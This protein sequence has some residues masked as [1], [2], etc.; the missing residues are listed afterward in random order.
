ME[1][2]DLLAVLVFDRR[3]LRG[4]SSADHIPCLVRRMPQGVQA[5]TCSA[6]SSARPSSASPSTT[7]ATIPIRSASSATRGREHHLVGARG[8]DQARQQPADPHVAVRRADVQEHRAEDRLGR[9]VADV[10]PEGE[11]EAEA[12]GRAIHCGDERLRGV[13]ELEVSRDM[14][15][16]FPSMSRALSLP[17]L[18]GAAT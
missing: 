8:A 6:A 14:C 11:R 15:S 17:S 7:A 13:P 1:R 16:W 3:S 12:G 4:I 9:C 18:P 2:H 10:A 5:A